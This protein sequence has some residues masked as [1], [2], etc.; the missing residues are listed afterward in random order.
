M[1]TSGSSAL[2]AAPPSND[3]SCWPPLRRWEP[4][5]TDLLLYLLFIKHSRCAWRFL[6]QCKSPALPF[7]TNDSRAPHTVMFSEIETL[8]KKPNLH[9]GCADTN[10]HWKPSSFQHYPIKTGIHVAQ[11]IFTK[12]Q[13]N[14]VFMRA[15]KGTMDRALRCV[16]TQRAGTTSTGLI[17]LAPANNVCLP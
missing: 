10:L 3:F 5:I 7:R 17:E 4:L 11:R 9:K 13:T 8:P 2:P 15:Q 12:G 14:G 6:S 16:K 1:G